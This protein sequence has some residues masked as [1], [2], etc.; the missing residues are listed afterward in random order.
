MYNYVCGVEST[1]LGEESDDV[2]FLVANL[3]GWILLSQV[4]RGK[5][6][7]VHDIK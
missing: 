3:V 7:F 5:C 2:V 6:L 1:Y 4:L